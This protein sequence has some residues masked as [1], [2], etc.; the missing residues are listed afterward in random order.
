MNPL[1]LVLVATIGALLAAC[2]AAIPDTARP[3]T[4]AELHSYL[5]GYTE[6][7][8]EGAG[9]Y[10]EDGTFVAVWEGEP[11]EGTWTTS[12]EG[13]LCWHSEAWGETPCSTYLFDG[14]SIIIIYEGETSPE[15]E[16]YEGNVVDNYM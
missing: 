4:A 9:Y 16:R 1:K 13:K 11:A 7:W 8:S 10:A 5:S 15:N 12:D 6:V 3:F 14:D 2:A